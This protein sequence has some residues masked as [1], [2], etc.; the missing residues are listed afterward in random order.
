MQFEGKTVCLDL[1]NSIQYKKKKQLIDTIAKHG[2]TISFILNK[3]V[4][5]LVKEDA[6]NLDTYKCRNAFKLGIPVVNIDY[7]NRLTQSIDSSPILINDYILKNKK[8]EQDLQK[9]FIPRN[10]STKKKPLERL[11]DLSTVKTYQ[12]END[13]LN[14]EFEQARFEIVKWIVFNEKSGS[15]SFIFEIHSQ[16]KNGEKKYRFRLEKITKKVEAQ[17]KSVQHVYASDAASIM[18][19][20]KQQ[21][22]S[23]LNEKLYVYEKVLPCPFVGSKMLQAVA[24]TSQAGK[25]IDKKT[26]LFVDYIWDEAIGDLYEIFESGLQLAHFTAE[27]LLKAEGVLYKQGANLSIDMSSEFYNILPNHKASHI[28]PINN[29]RV[30][31][32]KLELCQLIRDMISINEATNWNLKV[33]THS[34]Y[35]AIGS[36]IKALD[37]SSPQYSLLEKQIMEASGSVTI[38][39]IYEIIRPGESLTFNDQ[40]HNQKQLFH[41]SKVNNFSGILSRG[42]LLPKTVV[43]EYGGTRSDIGLLGAGIYFSDC[44]D[45]SLKYSSSSTVKNSRLITVCDVALGD[46]KHFYEISTKLTKPVKGFN[47]SHGVRKTNEIESEFT[48]SEYVVYDVNQC[49]IR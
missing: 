44:L 25:S 49:R 18:F 35:K 14:N 42:L 22:S 16:N 26:A 3:K 7:I 27:K 43:E 11:V 47:S 48:D 29:K 32:E 30:L 4:N 37:A 6:V 13:P 39:N 21:M 2:G 23:F 12:L 38:L 33:S 17:V 15:N 24:W 28:K 41:G 19:I 31:Y 45:T 20:F 1:T 8:N 40:M 9:G 10:E 34:K 46:C 5:Y 36:F